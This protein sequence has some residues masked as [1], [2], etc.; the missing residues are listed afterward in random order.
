[1]TS[2]AVSA[3]VRREVLIFSQRKL[4]AN[5]SRCSGY[6]FEDV[7]AEIEDAQV[8]TPTRSRQPRIP[9]NPKRWLSKRTDLFQ[10]WPSGVPQSRLTKGYDLFLCNV[11]RPDELL[12]LDAI[13]NWRDQCDTA[14]CVLEEVW[15]GDIDL[16]APLIKSLSQ[17]D[18]IACAFAETCGMIQDL[19]DTPVI[20]MPA[21]ADMIRFAPDSLNVDRPVDMYSMGRRRAELHQNL[22]AAIKQRQGF[23]IYDSAT[24]PPITGDHTVHRDLLANLIQHSKLFMVDIA[25]LG[26]ADQ[27]AGNIAWGPRHIEGFA[28]GAVQVGYAPDMEDYHR[29]FDWP[30]SVIRLPE[31]P[32]EALERIVALW[33]DPAEQDRIRRINFAHGLQKHDWMHRWAQVLDHLNL[34]EPDGMLKRRQHL[35]DIAGKLGATQQEQ[36]LGPNALP[37]T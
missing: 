34:P 22:L 5:I 12:V 36:T 25:K 37:T 10:H 23:Y 31:D 20:Q 7:V 30:D 32:D 4:N 33:D 1:V 16:Y 18:L 14:V 15:S 3:P 21:A 13:P 9:L 35:S 19:T 27:K 28:G 26:H 11:Q 6:E 24:K 29:F 2:S 17:F 8:L